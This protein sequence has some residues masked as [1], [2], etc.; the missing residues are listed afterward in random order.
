VCDSDYQRLGRPIA[1]KLWR[2]QHADRVDISG[3]DIGA[4]NPPGRD[5]FAELS[6]IFAG[7]TAL[8]S[9]WTAARPIRAAMR[10]G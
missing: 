4:L 1:G 9:G 10:Q 8:A 7:G 5:T 3:C 6:C 2:Q